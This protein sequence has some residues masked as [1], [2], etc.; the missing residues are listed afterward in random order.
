VCNTNHETVRGGQERSSL[1]ECGE[2]GG[3]CVVASGVRDLSVGGF[4]SRNSVDVIVFKHGCVYKELDKG[5][6]DDTVCRKQSTKRTIT[7]LSSVSSKNTHGVRKSHVGIGLEF[8]WSG[9]FW[10]SLRYLRLI[11]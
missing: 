7:Q 3:N 2:S 1:V 10:R 11:T 8:Q 4:T 9:N 6:Q 5:G